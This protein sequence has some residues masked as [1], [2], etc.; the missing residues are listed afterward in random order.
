MC[1]NVYHS[2]QDVKSSIKDHKIAC[3]QFRTNNE[4]NVEDEE[5]VNEIQVETEKANQLLLLEKKIDSL[6]QLQLNALT[7]EQSQQLTAQG[8]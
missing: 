3:A 1:I 8:N 4:M 5:R 2:S 7:K 6:Q